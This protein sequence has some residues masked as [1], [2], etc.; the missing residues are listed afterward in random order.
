MTT[1][2]EQRYRRLLRVLPAWYRAD[3]EREMVDVFLEGRAE[4]DDADLD[5]EH[6]WPGWGE[7]ASVAALAVRTRVGG[8]GAPP[9]PRAVGNAV[10]A[11]AGVGVLLNAAAAAAGVLGRVVATVAGPPAAEVVTGTLLHPVG[12][13]AW[14]STVALVLG[15]CWLP[16]WTALTSGRAG[17]AVL[18]ALAACLPT[19]VGLVVGDGPV[20][21][22]LAGSLVAIATVVLL[23]LGHHR[24]AAPPDVARPWALLAVATVALAAIAPLVLVVRQVL[25]LEAVVL[26][27]AAVV[28]AVTGRRS[29]LAAGIAVVSAV[30]VVGG[31]LELAA[32]DVDRTGSAITVGVGLVATLVAV[33]AARRD[34]PS[35]LSVIL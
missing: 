20:L 3:R 32:L 10:R 13:G 27:V 14:W 8:E 15:L 11:A 1:R 34:V 19:L 21:W 7:T 5:A 24:D 35:H 2:L 18:L 29:A 23:L 30:V 9:G 6:G 31:L 4:R 17:A 26:L 16:A 33:V 12:A 25:A 28:V 22:H